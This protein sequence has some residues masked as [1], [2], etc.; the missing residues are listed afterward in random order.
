MK[1]PEFIKSEITEKKGYVFY[2]DMEDETHILQGKNYIVYK[3]DFFSTL[4][5]FMR[6]TK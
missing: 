1:K 3:G 5:K 4:K 2:P 6:L